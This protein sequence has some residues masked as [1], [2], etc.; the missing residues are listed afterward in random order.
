MAGVIITEENF[1]KEVLQS[2]IPVLVDFWAEWCGPCKMLAP[3]LDSLAEKYK[4]KVK[5]GKI[6]VDEQKNIAI[7]YRIASIPTVMVF[8][9]GKAMSI[10][11]GF[12]TKEQLETMIEGILLKG[13][14]V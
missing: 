14:T 1:K 12:Q 9:Q 2:D 10:S 7:R 5:I 13:N 8:V 6:N 4:G 11:V 3:G